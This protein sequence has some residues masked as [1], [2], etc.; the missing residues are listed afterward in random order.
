MWI[1][2]DWTKTKFFGPF[3]SKLE[4]EEWLAKQGIYAS[5]YGDNDVSIN[6]LSPKTERIE[7]L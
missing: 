5:Q 1:V 2:V 7:L 6:E 4:A 3:Q